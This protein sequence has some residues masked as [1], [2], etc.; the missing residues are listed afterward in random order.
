MVRPL[1]NIAS[2]ERYGEALLLLAAFYLLGDAGLWMARLAELVFIM[3]LLLIISHPA[4][5]RPLK[6]TA[7]VASSVSAVLTFTRAYEGTP[8]TVTLGA[9]STLVVVVITIVAVLRRLLAHT[10]VTVSTVLGAF[11]CYA[12]IGFGAAFLYIT[13]DALTG[14]PFFTQG[15]QPEANYIYFSM[16]TL[17]TVGY[18]DLTAGTALA[19]RLVVIEALVGQVFLV[20]LVARLV[21]LWKAPMRN[22][23]RQD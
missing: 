14:Q 6:W 3:I 18:G 21:S 1:R 5:P 8:A 16:V 19:K 17:T 7:W 13:V 12:L 22:L 15:P 9:A 20:V 2:Q 11:L 10:D 23:N 4:V